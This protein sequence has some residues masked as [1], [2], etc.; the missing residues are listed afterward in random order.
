MIP[1]DL[2][3][4]LGDWASVETDACLLRMT[5][6]EPGEGGSQDAYTSRLTISISEVNVRC[7]G[8]LS[9]ISNRR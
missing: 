8:H 4:E 1:K 7:T 6:V 3:A 2:R 9:A 5:G